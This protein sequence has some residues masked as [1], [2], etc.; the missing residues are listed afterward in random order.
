MALLYKAENIKLEERSVY[1]EGIQFFAPTLAG[2][3]FCPKI[4]FESFW[5]NEYKVPNDILAQYSQD[6]ETFNEEKGVWRGRYTVERSYKKEKLGDIL[7]NNEFTIQSQIA[8]FSKKKYE[9]SQILICLNKDKIVYKR[10]FS[11]YKLELTNFLSDLT[12][13]LEKFDNLVYTV[14]IYN[15][16]IAPLGDISHYIKQYMDKDI[17]ANSWEEPD[18][19]K[20]K[21]FNNIL[22]YLQIMKKFKKDLSDFVNILKNYLLKIKELNIDFDDNNL[23][24]FYKEIEKFNI[25]IT[26]DYNY[27]IKIVKDGKVYTEDFLNYLIAREDYYETNSDDFYNNLAINLKKSLLDVNK[28]VG[29]FY[30]PIKSFTIF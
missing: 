28:H 3:I 19:T 4:L 27:I 6:T 9:Y 23:N 7:T 1:N 14:N 30:Q 13:Q 12:F 29:K 15:N 16:F 8:I 22:S 2:A 20:E 11:E 24:D 17:H 26:E 25:M 18:F 21:S 10:K 5:V